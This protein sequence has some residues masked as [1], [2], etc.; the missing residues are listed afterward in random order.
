MKKI[1]AGLVCGAVMLAGFIPAAF[2]VSSASVSMQATSDQAAT[3][4]NLSD[5]AQE[6]TAVSLSFQVNVTA[7]SSEKASVWFAFDSGL[8]AN[9][10]EYRYNA[11]T[12]RLTLY[13]SGKD[14]LFQQDSTLLGSIKAS[15][16]DATGLTVSVQPISDS[17]KLVNTSSEVMN[18]PAI[19]TGSV[20]QLVVG[21]GGENNAAKVDFTALANAVATAEAKNAAEYTTDSWNA[22]QAALRSAK[23]VL[24]AADSTQESVDAATNALNA[25]IQGLAAAGGS[26][27]GNSS[28]GTGTAP[29]TPT[30]P[31]PG[32]VNTV[33]TP[34]NNPAGAASS[35][36]N[37]KPA[38]S[39]SSSSA[40]SSSESKSEAPSSTSASSSAP[41]SESAAPA[42]SG[43]NAEAAQAQPTGNIANTIMI[44]VII[45]LVIAIIGVGIAIVR[46]RR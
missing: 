19:D 46:K 8:P 26:S 13:L 32:G 15:T 29:T 30:T 34:A 21:E 31:T 37:K 14:A 38:S 41:A 17:L 28:G 2:A 43:S 44:G 45:L 16:Q 23:A 27:S 9:I 39:G 36:A 12:G 4:L 3:T 40:A 22:L 11:Q 18:A 5:S 35:S 6:V 42:Q 25:A 20:V 24:A 10:Q 33:T 7:G 1:I